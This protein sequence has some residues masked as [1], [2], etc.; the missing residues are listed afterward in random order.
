MPMTRRTTLYG[1]LVPLNNCLQA[2]PRTSETP[3]K[4]TAS[5]G[6]ESLSAEYDNDKLVFSGDMYGN[7]ASVI[8]VISVNRKQRMLLICLAVK[9]NGGL[10]ILNGSD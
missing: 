3:A 2:V 7:A 1:T 10:E 6:L 8:L 4:I 9:I 5:T